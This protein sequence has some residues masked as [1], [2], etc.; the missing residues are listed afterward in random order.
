M[1]CVQFASV[2]KKYNIGNSWHCGKICVPLISR[3]RAENRGDGD[4]VSRPRARTRGGDG[5]V[6][7]KSRRPGRERNG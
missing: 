3:G 4:I 6:S 7:T 1:R 5:D 2:V